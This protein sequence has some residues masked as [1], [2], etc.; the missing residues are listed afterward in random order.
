MSLEQRLTETITQAVRRAPAPTFDLADIRRGAR[1]RTAVRAVAVTA[2]VVVVVGLAGTRLAGDDD[3]LPPVDHPSSTP[4]PSPSPSP[5][6]STAPNVIPDVRDEQVV[7]TWDQPPLPPSVS[8]LLGRATSGDADYSGDGEVSVTASVHAYMREDGFGWERYCS[9]APSTWWVFTVEPQISFLDV[10]RCDGSG[11]PSSAPAPD[12]LDGPMV[13]EPGDLS[14]RTTDVEVR[15]FLTDQDP[16]AYYDCVAHSPPEGCADTEPPHA[17]GTG[18]RFGVALYG[19]Q[20]AVPATTIFG[21]EVYPSA[22]ML[23]TTYSFTSAVAAATG[24]RLL[25]YRLPASTHGRIL[26]A[27]AGQEEPCRHTGGQ[28]SPDCLPVPKLRIDGQL[29]GNPNDFLFTTLGP[30]AQLAP[31]GAH[32]VTLEIPASD[33]DVLDLGFVVFEARDN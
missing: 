29:V 24:S 33:T 15:M 27:M 21:S 19:R 32:E 12:T 9:G 20:P 7:V 3:T 22:R 2:A 23:D 5:S 1:R 13:G 4:T 31:G 10:G 8:T 11:Q 26:Q 17:V 6:A 25:T 16:T 30:R 18:A 28:R 14:G